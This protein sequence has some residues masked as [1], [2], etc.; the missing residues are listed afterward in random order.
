[1]TLSSTIEE[2]AVK[3]RNLETYLNDHLAGSTA[4]LELLDTLARLEGL[5]Q[6]AVRLRHAVAEDQEQ[7]L[8]LMRSLSIDASIV[9]R[10]VSWV[11]E[12]AAEI[13]TAAVDVE[14][15]SLRQLELL[16]A[17]ALGVDGRGA[18]WQALDA[19]AAADPSLAR[20]DYQKLIA[21]AMQQRDEIEVLRLAAATAAIGSP[22][23]SSRLP[24]PPAASVPLRVRASSD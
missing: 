2:S 12:K 21:R 1:M 23:G 24:D 4:G 9:R 6:A 14:A 18:L 19:A 5:E 11:A 17:L 22:G 16:E 8:A 7:L 10:V 15:G 3:R 13:K 20:L